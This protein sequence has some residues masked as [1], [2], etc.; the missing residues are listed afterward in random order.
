[1]ISASEYCKNNHLAILANNLIFCW[2]RFELAP[3]G[4]LNHLAKC[5]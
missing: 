4:G 1:M 3:L 5:G 2:R